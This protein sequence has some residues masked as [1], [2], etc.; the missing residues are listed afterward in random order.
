MNPIP[1]I[2]LKARYGRTPDEVYGIGYLDG[3]I[4]SLERLEGEV[5]S[6][7]EKIFRIAQLYIDGVIESKA[8]RKASY[9]EWEAK[10]SALRAINYAGM[11]AMDSFYRGEGINE[12]QL[13]ETILPHADTIL[14]HGSLRASKKR[15][16]TGV[17]DSVQDR[18]LTLQRSLEKIGPLD[19]IVAVASGALEPAYVLA[20][21]LE[22]PEVAAA[23]L[24]RM[25][26]N[27]SRVK[28]PTRDTDRYLRWHCEGK[29]VLVVEDIA[30]E[31]VSMAK[32]L[33]K[34]IEYNPKRV[35]GLIIKGKPATVLGKVSSKLYQRT[36]G[37]NTGIFEVKR[38]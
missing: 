3:L 21:V 35:V 24:S 26:K 18:I 17:V 4:Q 7:R 37:E 22:I 11:Q 36:L 29:N 19:S 2:D 31:G 14:R 38:E 12:E 33:K 34:A 9:E 23:R 28:T 30:L 16:L 27:D 25:A 8:N 15:H 32:V 1:S 13:R 10:D 6:N 20:K 5:H